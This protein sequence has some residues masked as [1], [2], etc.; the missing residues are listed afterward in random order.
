MNPPTG[1]YLKKGDT[2]SSDIDA[3]IGDNRPDVNVDND[4]RYNANETSPYRKK[5]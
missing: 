2:N 3:D 4:E 5:K 1:K